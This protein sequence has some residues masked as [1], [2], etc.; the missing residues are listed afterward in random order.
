M[1][2][3]AFLCVMF[4]MGNITPAYAHLS[5]DFIYSESIDSSSTIIIWVYGK[6]GSIRM[7]EYHPKFDVPYM[8]QFYPAWVKEI[9]KKTNGAITDMAVYPCEIILTKKD[10]AQW[11]TIFPIIFPILKMHVVLGGSLEDVLRKEND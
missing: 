7:T 10:A 2:R 3:I 5:K 8:Q 1:R 4:L 6:H 11:G 9:F